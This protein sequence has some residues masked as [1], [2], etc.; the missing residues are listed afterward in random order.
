MILYRLPFETN[1]THATDQ[2]EQAAE[3]LKHP[4]L[5]PYVLQ[6]NLK[7]SPS[8]NMLPV[9][10]TM[11]NHIRKIRFQDGE[12]ESPYKCERRKSLGSERILK[13]NKR[14]EQNSLTSTQTIRE[15]PNYLN[16]RIKNLSV[17]S[18]QVGEIG[19]NKAISEK[20]SSTL[21]TPRHTSIKTLMAPRM[22]VETLKVFHTGQK[23][24]SIRL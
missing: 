15:S 21:K 13:L 12:D 11:G 19:I 22:P 23:H 7:S 4:H 6:V 16:T 1:I 10:Q 14:V 18:S 5:Q 2:Y 20:H 17:G 8:R 9:H 24:E 3:L